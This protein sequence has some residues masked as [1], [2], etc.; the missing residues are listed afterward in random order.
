MRGEA[1]P[2]PRRGM[3]DSLQSNT[4]TYSSDKVVLYHSFAKFTVARITNSITDS[5][6]GGGDQ[7]RLPSFPESHDIFATRYSRRDFPGLPGFSVPMECLCKRRHTRTFFSRE[8]C[9][10][11]A[12]RSGSHEVFP[13]WCLASSTVSSL[14]WSSHP[15]VRSFVRSF[16]HVLRRFRPR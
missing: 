11:L 6:G 16:A 4:D 15:S 8:T 13:T 9:T 7:D 12:A 1:F 5:E 14:V 10:A 3:I 2:R